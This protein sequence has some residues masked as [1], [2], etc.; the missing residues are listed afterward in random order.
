M[1]ADTRNTHHIPGKEDTFTD[2]FVKVARTDRFL[3]FNYGFNRIGGYDW[4]KLRERLTPEPENA[5]F[6]KIQ[7]ELKRKK[8]HLAG[9]VFVSTDEI[10]EIVVTQDAVT[11]KGEANRWWVKR[12]CARDKV[13]GKQ[14]DPLEQKG[15]YEVAA[16]LLS[17]INDA[18]QAEV[19]KSTAKFNADPTVSILW[20]KSP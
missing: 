20:K 10:R 2:D 15:V 13:D 9:Y 19:E 5:I 11:S 12:G 16:K 17:L 1:L 3:I 4:K 8:R 7:D 18:H 6:S 14:I